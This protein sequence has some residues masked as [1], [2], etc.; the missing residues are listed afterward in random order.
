M[1]KILVDE[2]LPR[3]ISDWLKSLG[4]DVVRTSDVN[5]KGAKD[6]AVAEKSAKDSRIIITLDLDFAYIYTNIMRGQL[7]VI[8]IRIH[9]A[10][11]ANIR[12]TLEKTLTKIDIDKL[13]KSLIV[14][15]RKKIR[16]IT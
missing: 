15:S 3:S 13:D 8:V 1:A 6:R 14:V 4:H 16:I 9:P 11:P 5:L 2:N 12:E 7:T 10:T